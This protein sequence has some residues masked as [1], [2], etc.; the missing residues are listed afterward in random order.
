[1]QKGERANRL[2]SM[3]DIELDTEDAQ[4]DGKSPLKSE[5]KH[6]GLLKGWLGG[7]F[8]KAR[9]RSKESLRDLSRT[10]AAVGDRIKSTPAAERLNA[11]VD[12]RRVIRKA[13]DA[14][15]RQ[16]HPMAYRLLEPL[17][18]E[19]PDDPQVVVAFWGAARACNRADEA[20]PALAHTLRVLTSAGKLERAAELWRELHEIAPETLLDPGSLARI[21]PALQE[22]CPPELVVAALRDA[23]DPRNTGLS[24][25]IAVRIAEIALEPDP[26]TALRAAR[27]ALASPDLHES[28]RKYL[29]GMVARGE[30][31]GDE[32]QPLRTTRV[33]GTEAPADPGHPQGT[34]AA[35][36]D[37]VAPATRFRA[38]K[39]TE[40]M[41]IGFQDAA[42]VLQIEGGRRAS[43]AYEQIE[44][45]AVATIAD[46]VAIDL[47]LNWS[48][49]GD[50]VL[51]LVR[52]KS[53]G[54]DPRMVFEASGVH[55]DPLAAFLTELM[56]RSEATPL[57]DPESALGLNIRAYASMALYQRE[58]LR[59]ESEAP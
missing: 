53:N 43:V 10:V 57:P 19:R 48:H 32:A 23:V 4:E 9:E 56:A 34:L 2:P 41:P 3:A 28:R 49:D 40:A 6:A 46:F 14:Q 12:A 21:M 58:V 24:P 55:A 42:I 45:V 37:H 30:R 27:F 11:A 13:A 20:A 39:V 8:G 52:L 38:V 31:A 17:A 25:G 16:N 51:R 1:M 22:S 33:E 36:I 7:A 44:A 18:R 29:E 50:E 35:V 59:V 54:F 47:V 15:R 26:P 5:G